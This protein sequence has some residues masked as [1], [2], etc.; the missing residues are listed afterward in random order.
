MTDFYKNSPKWNQEV[1]NRLWG[2]LPDSSYSPYDTPVYV[3]G[4]VIAFVG[5]TTTA[6]ISLTDLTGGI[7]SS[8]SANDVV[9]VAFGC[10]STTNIDLNISDYT[11]L[12]DLYA[13]DTE[14][15]NLG[16]YYKVM[17]ATPDTQLTRSSTGS[18]DNAGA[19]AIQ[20]WRNIDTTNPIDVTTT[21]ATGT[22][23]V[24][25]NP[26]AITPVTQNAVIIA[27]GF[28][29]H[30]A[31]NNFTYS[32]SNL[33]NF[34]T[35]G[36]DDVNDSTIGMGSR[37][38]TGG[39]FDPAAFTFSGSSSNAYSWTAASMALRP[40]LS[41]AQV[42]YTKGFS[43]N[44]QKSA[45]SGKL[46]NTEIGSTYSLVYTTTSGAHL[47]AVL[48]P[49]GDIHFI[50][51][52]GNRG[53]KV[54]ASGVVS[55]YALVYT[56]SSGTLWQGGVLGA[57]GDIHFV[58]FGAIRG[59]KVS[60]SGV[61]STYSLAYTTAG[62]GCRGGVL[63][64]NGDIHF[65]PYF[66]T[67]VGHKVSVNGGA[68]TYS[69][70]YTGGFA[71]SGGVLAPNGDIHFVPLSAPVGQKI[72]AA[73]VVS[74]YSLIFTAGAAYTGGV[75]APNGD[76]HFIPNQAT[77]GQK[78]S[79][80]GVVSTYSL[81]YTSGAYITGAAGGAINAEGEIHFA[82]NT[83]PLGQKISTLPARRFTQGMAQN[84]FFNKF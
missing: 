76:I 15:S 74:T 3:G 20:V 10:A 80:A 42:D 6:T 50:P 84:A 63:A 44:V 47:G 48:A 82:P 75:L 36:Q 41:V 21:T 68:S 24:L 29:A 67:P 62:P 77:V 73:G 4:K 23:G 61:V 57:N 9:V 35:A 64:S 1:K 45:T 55:T 30:V 78:I 66:S 31:G 49:N 51:G 2:S 34:L 11:E 33:S 32:S 79:P 12:V 22:N 53:Q 59:Q 83:A 52:N 28:G 5:D 81:A 8:P 46:F 39:A 25:A 71:Y 56:T 17:G 43:N 70:V 65:V 13:D 58:P 27:V 69:L 72:S 38:S 40:T 54:S 14:D 16:L 37:I 19:V 60:P 7:A 18:V 26:P